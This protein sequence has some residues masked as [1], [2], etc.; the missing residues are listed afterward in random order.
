MESLNNALHC[1]NLNDNFF[2]LVAHTDDQKK[3]MY[4]GELMALNRFTIS[5]GN[6]Y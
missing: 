2:Q 1:S 3:S 5:V 6:P 4:G